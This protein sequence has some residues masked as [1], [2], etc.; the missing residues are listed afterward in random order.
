MESNHSGSAWPTKSALGNVQQLPLT[1]TIHG[2]PSQ[3]PRQGVRIHARALHAAGLCLLCRELGH[4]KRLC[5]KWTHGPERQYPGNFDTEDD[6][7][8]Y[9]RESVECITKL[10]VDVKRGTQSA[11]RSV[12]C[13]AKGENF[14]R[15]CDGRD[16]NPKNARDIK[17]IECEGAVGGKGY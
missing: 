9:L 6:S 14:V 7:K 4:L 12:S 17:V 11:K 1:R 16:I 13:D 5:T 8:G 10:P 15:P 3:Q 2:V